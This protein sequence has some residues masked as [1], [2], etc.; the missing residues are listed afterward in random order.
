MLHHNKVPNVIIN[1][2]AAKSLKKPQMKATAALKKQIVK[3]KLAGVCSV[4]ISEKTGATDSIIQTAWKE[5]RKAHPEAAHVPKG[6]RRKTLTKGAM[7][8]IVDPS[9]L[10]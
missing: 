9:D 8:D 2:Q 10:A 4:E 1:P 3:L 7:A 6:N 5:Y